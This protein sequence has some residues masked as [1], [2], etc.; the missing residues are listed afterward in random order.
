[1][2]LGAITTVPGILCGRF[3]DT[4]RPTACTV[5]PAPAGAIG[6]VDARGGAPCTRATDLA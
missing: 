2:T 1:M 6:G 5:V 4:R 3:T